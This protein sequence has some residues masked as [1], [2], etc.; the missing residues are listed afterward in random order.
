MAFTG[1]A[2][3][4][5]QFSSDIATR[6]KTPLIVSLI[7]PIEILRQAGVDPVA[8]SF[9]AADLARGQSTQR[10]LAQSA[11]VPAPAAV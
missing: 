2:R 9:R 7:G 3:K 4:P 10:A 5:R 1:S 6:G 11:P 8:E